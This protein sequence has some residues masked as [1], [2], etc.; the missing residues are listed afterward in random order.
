MNRALSIGDFTVWG[1]SEGHFLL[2]GGAMFGVVPKPLWE[3]KAPADGLN[4]IKLG[5]NSVLIKTPGALVLVETGIGTKGGKRLSEIYDVH[6]EPG[7]VPSI[8]AAGFKPEDVD[9]VI[10][11]HLHFDH[12]GGNTL[13][14]EG[15]ALAPTFPRARYVLQRA[16][17][18]DALH[19]TERD[20]SGY[21]QENFLPLESA[22]RVHFVEG[23]A[24][25]VPGVDVVATPGHTRAHQSVRVRSQG[26][27]LFYLGDLVPTAAHVPL[28]YVMSYDLFPVETLKTKKKVYEQAIREDWILALVHDPVHYFGRV[29]ASGRKYEFVP[30]EPQETFER[31]NV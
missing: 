13:I 12:C 15:G 23:D 2:D 18:E 26:R 24:E 14:A 20:R 5:L 3:K 10:N 25:I 29:A 16:E 6:L 27:T 17:W 19:P 28:A 11:T 30:L 7:L 1:L 31:Y 22:G 4:R 21:P 9:F 8:A